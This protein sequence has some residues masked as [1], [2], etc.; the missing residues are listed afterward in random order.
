MDRRQAP[1][2]LHLS[3]VSHVRVEALVCPAWLQEANA[4]S[5]V[6]V[7][8]CQGTF[9]EGL[10]AL[11]LRALSRRLGWDAMPHEGPLRHLSRARR[12]RGLG[13]EPR[14]RFVVPVVRPAGK[15]RGD[16]DGPGEVAAR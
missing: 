14:S 9:G 13:L 15:R 1:Q 11:K 10:W 3:L 8:A 2:R 12:A 4:G 16:P 6:E 5:R 7:A